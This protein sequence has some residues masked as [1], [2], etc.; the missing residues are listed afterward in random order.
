MPALHTFAPDLTIDGENGL[1]LS[2]ERALC[3]RFAPSLPPNSDKMETSFVI[4]VALSVAIVVVIL[5][6]VGTIVFQRWRISDQNIHLKKFINE[7]IELHEKLDR[8][9]M[10]RRRI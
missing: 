5:I 2:K 9:K 6:L 8:V 10:T 3:I 7:N 1:R 4:A